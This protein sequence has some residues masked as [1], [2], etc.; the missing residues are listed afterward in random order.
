MK[1][2]K[3]RKIKN[4]GYGMALGKIKPDATKEDFISITSK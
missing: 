2:I 3:L 4:T 1:I